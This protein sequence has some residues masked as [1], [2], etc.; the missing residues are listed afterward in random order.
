MSSGPDH[1]LV[2]AHQLLSAASVAAS[3]DSCRRHAWAA[4]DCAIR[5]MTDTASTPE[6]RRAAFDHVQ[7]AHVRLDKADTRPEDPDA[8]QE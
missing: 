3:R 5:V 4:L 2:K 6:Q 8:S 1:V 7:Q